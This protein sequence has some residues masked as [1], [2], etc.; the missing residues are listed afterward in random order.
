LSLVTAGRRALDRIDHDEGARPSDFR[1]LQTELLFERGPQARHRAGAERPSRLALYRH[2]VQSAASRLGA[3]DGGRRWRVR[4]T[5]T[6]LHRRRT[7]NAAPHRTG[8]GFMQQHLHSTTA[9]RA[10]GQGVD[11]R[12]ALGPWQRRSANRSRL[13]QTNPDGQQEHD[14]AADPGADQKGLE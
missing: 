8:H 9:V 13:P 1:E 2:H 10:R 11:D 7:Q 12:T 6:L 14:G 4:I 3:G 5:I